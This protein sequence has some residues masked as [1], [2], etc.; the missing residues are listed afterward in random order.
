MRVQAPILQALSLWLGCAQ[1]A[2]CIVYPNHQRVEQLNEIPRGWSRGTKPPPT[3]LI[4]LRLA[5]T[6]SNAAEFEQH[7]IDISTPGHLKYG[8]HMK[9]DEVKELLRPSPAIS[10]KILEWL[11][12]E[13]VWPDAIQPDGNWILFTVPINQAEHMLRSEFFYYH[14]EAQK[15]PVIRTLGYSVP[16][17]ILPYIQL[18]QPTTRFGNI[19]PRKLTMLKHELATPEQLAS[20]CD[21]AITPSCLHNLYGIGNV[22]TTPDRRNRL[23]VSGFLEQYARH[24]DLEEFF[25]HYSP[26]QTNNN[27]TV[28]SIN[29]GKNDQDSDL[30]SVEANLDIQ[31]SI[32]MTDQVL[33]I[34]YTTAG[35]GP[36]V[37]EIDQ[38]DPANASD[39]PYLE[40]LHYLLGLPDDELPAVLTN[41]YGEHEQ[42]LP[43]SYVNATCNLFAQLGARGVSII[44]ASGDSGPGNSC[45]M[46]DG[47]NR[48]RFL[49]EYPTSC[50]FV[51]SVGG[52]ER[53][54]PERATYF[55]G[56][57]FSEI[58]SRPSY[59]DQAVESYLKI[60]GGQW[61][62]LYN[63]HGRGVPDVA[64]QS[65]RFVVRDH[66]KWI[67]VAG[68]SASAPVFAGI[69]SRLND[70]R[71]A[72]GKPRMGFLNPWLYGEGR[73]AFN[74]IVHGR[75]GG[76]DG[77]SG[78]VSTPRV[79]NAGWSATEG[80]DP[81][82]GLGTPSFQE[83]LKLAL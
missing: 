39:E 3:Q 25:A 13:N 23:G 28:V 36:A 24:G 48:T 67:S 62:G 27:F 21:E 64:T 5:I 59:Q 80:W 65:T 83:L 38:P 14:N 35:R 17:D 20:G 44:F 19:S 6:Q 58:F 75:S 41:S 2:S 78:G 8:K 74:D 52:T 63:P 40:Q 71:L 31:Y 54:N 76:C 26:H 45:L 29:G 57:G 60:L 37:P 69:I 68:T 33:T 49:A 55:S 16:S 34:F 53:I 77:W 46:N 56:G 51:T 30:D 43:A 10:N 73:L 61:E 4:K 47:T 70:A 11:R 7:V 82:T 12:S 42:G 15:E 66:N 72:Q 50:P 1:I 79:P 9:R 22:S 81:V 18:I 32:A